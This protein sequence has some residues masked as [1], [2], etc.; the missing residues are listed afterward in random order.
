MR[1]G[2]CV[3]DIIDSTYIYI[4]DSKPVY[5]HACNKHRKNLASVLSN[6]TLNTA[7]HFVLSDLV[8]TS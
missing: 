5:V 6:R 7:Y 4:L 1:V 3:Y 8:H 2:M